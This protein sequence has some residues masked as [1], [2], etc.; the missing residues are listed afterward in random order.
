MMADRARTWLLCIG[1]CVF[2]PLGLLAKQS[3][4]TS[5]IAMAALVILAVAASAPRALLPNKAVAVVF[6]L[7]AVYVAAT[8]LFILD[9]EACAAK[10]GG[11]MAMLALVLWVASSDIGRVA[12]EARR[13]IGLALTTGLFVAIAL[14]VFE[15]SSD[16]TFFRMIT[17]RQDDPD[18][19][20]F[21]LNRGTTALVLLAWPAA[22]WLWSIERRPLA[23]ALV[24]LS[25]GAAA[26]GDSASAMVAGLLAVI[27]AAA[28]ALA[29]TATVTVGLLIAGAFTALAPWLLLNLLGWVLFREWG[30]FQD[31]ALFQAYTIRGIALL[32]CSSVP[33]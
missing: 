5:F 23:I 8:H 32:K 30:I 22:A 25:I 31:W 33:Y 21:R 2:V 3:L 14:L 6:A 24:M 1:F 16:S 19:P 28:A 7:L 29:P 11:K 15:L 18:V 17:G 13:A 26:Y 9:C 4:A 10:A 27:A 12:P 20:L